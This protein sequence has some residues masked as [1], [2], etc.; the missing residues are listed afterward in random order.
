MRRRGLVLR[1]TIDIS[2]KL[3]SILFVTVAVA[4][5]LWILY[6][7]CSKG[8]EA[9]SW[10]FFVEPTKPYGIP[11]GGIANALLG[12]VII[13]I[14]AVII[15]V[16]PGLLGGIYLSEFARNSKLGNIIRFSANVM[17]GIPSII[18][19]LFVYAMLVYSTKHFSGFAGSVALSVIM[20]PVILRTT[21]DMLCMVPDALR[22]SALAIG[23]PR[24]R[25]TFSIVCKAASSG[26]VTGVLLAI[27]RVSGET[28][29]LLFTALW[30]D[31]WPFTFFTQPTAN[32]TVTIN[33]Y[34]TNSPFNVMH[35]RAWGAALVI[36][37]IIL[38]LNISC[39]II[40]KNKE[41]AS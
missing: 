11:D 16:P 18:C 21:E 6:T 41:H 28:A 5:M 38:I 36:T 25:A 17:M 27:A 8:I 26:L 33:E 35:T 39:R 31:D 7:V 14:G 12:T 34:A 13:T 30:S 20:F 23:M 4:V 22:E 29:P 3:L 37:F 9:F 32:L 19:G 10:S 1:K 40:F 2:M 24:W 15:G